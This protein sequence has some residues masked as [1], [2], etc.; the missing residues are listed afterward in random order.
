MTQPYIYDESSTL[1]Y[2][3]SSTFQYLDNFQ[4]FDPDYNEYQPIGSAWP[5]TT[6]HIGSTMPPFY[7]EPSV[8]TQQSHLQSLPSQSPVPQQD[9]NP[10]SI[11]PYGPMY[12]YPI[13]FE[14]PR[15][16][17]YYPKS[18]RR[19]IQAVEYSPVSDT[20]TVT[21]LSPKK[22]VI[23]L[24]WRNNDSVAPMKEVPNPA[25]KRKTI[26]IA[27]ASERNSQ[28]VK[29]SAQS[30][31][32]QA[33]TTRSLED[34]MGLFDTTL[35]ATKEK[36]RRKVFSAQEKKVVKSVRNVGA[37]IPCRFRKKT[38]SQIVVVMAAVLIVPAP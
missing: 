30:S 21:R 34:C 22:P 1:H 5:S 20:D 17:P 26:S 31:P 4:T 14:A 12:G 27:P 11:G 29:A 16:L 3:E 9:L 7:E 35:T 18:P 28:D 2:E 25:K 36:R 37:C 6:E 15:I 13:T 32:Q 23:A 10:A 38:V 24:E 8:P 33:L 19:Q